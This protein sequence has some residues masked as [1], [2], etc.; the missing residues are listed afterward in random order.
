MKRRG[1]W[2]TP[3]V[4]LAFGLAL[5]LTGCDSPM[6]NDPTDP[7]QTGSG[8]SGPSG[9]SAPARV[10]A[11]ITITGIPSEYHGSW[12]NLELMFPDTG[13]RTGWSRVDTIGSTATFTLSVVPGIYHVFFSHGWGT[14]VIPSID[15]TEGANTIPWSAIAPPLTITVTG[16]PSEYHSSWGTIELIF[17]NTGNRVGSGSTHITGTSAT[18]TLAGLSGLYEVRLRFGSD[19]NA[20]VYRTRN[21][22]YLYPEGA[23]TIPFSAF[24]FMPPITVT[25]T[26][27]PSQYQDNVWGEIVFMVP[28]TA[29]GIAWGEARITGSSVTFTL[30]NVAPGTY[31]VHLLFFN[32]ELLGIYTI[33]AR[34]ITEDNSIPFGQFAVL[35][36][37]VTI[38]VTGIPSG[39][40]DGFGEMDLR[41]TATG[42]WRSD[43]W[44]AITG[45]S[46]VFRFWFVDPGTYDV[47]LWVEGS[48]RWGE[49]IA[50]ARNIARNTTIPWSAFNFVYGGELMPITITGI[51]SRYHGDWGDLY[52]Y[53]PGTSNRVARNEV[54]P[55]SSSTTFGL[56][57]APGIYD[58]VLWLND[59]GVRYTLPSRNISPGI[60][61]PFDQ[62][63]PSPIVLSGVLE[64]QERTPRGRSRERLLRDR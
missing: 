34:N 40:Q 19:D 29:S 8:P 25:I 60:N 54:F 51:P 55:V 9:P 62:F 57:A 14:H 28:G 31:D 42:D 45:S 46:A 38:T 1:L 18:F 11:T 59:Y 16:I 50:S 61:I 39:Y 35:P 53:F 58:V 10:P 12:G 49:A 48:T 32:G 44:T 6:N 4:L 43:S 56:R 5:A 33:S 22:T 15:I 27:I 47:Y 52:L 20:R 21:I 24:A 23:N 63:T 17:P 2:K 7:G 36:P 41:C 37:S 3:A 64:Q 30:G 13:N 26:G